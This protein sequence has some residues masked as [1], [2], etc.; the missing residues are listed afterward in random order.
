MHIWE[1]TSGLDP[2]PK[3]RLATTVK[4]KRPKKH[5]SDFERNARKLRSRERE[6]NAVGPVSP[7]KHRPWRLRRKLDILASWLA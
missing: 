4:R 1:V 5:V 7:I 6:L 3:P 2:A